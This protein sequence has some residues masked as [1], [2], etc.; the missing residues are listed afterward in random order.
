VRIV[1]SGGLIGLGHR[2]EIRGILGV[3]VLRVWLDE[4]KRMRWWIGGEN[5]VRGNNLTVTDMHQ[6]CAIRDRTSCSILPKV[7]KL[8]S[9]YTTDIGMALQI[10]HSLNSR[11]VRTEREIKVGT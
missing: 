4:R 1:I 7:E 8:R 11:V 10:T 9:W 5:G 2:R 6:V 3:E